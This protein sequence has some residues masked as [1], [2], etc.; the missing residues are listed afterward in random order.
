MLH[1][2]VLETRFL[3]SLL[4]NIVITDTIGD[5]NDQIMNFGNIGVGH[6]SNPYSLTIQNNNPV[7]IFITSLSTDDPAFTVPAFTTTKIQPN[8]QITVNDIRFAPTVKGLQETGL[9]LHVTAEGLPDEADSKVHLIGTGLPSDLTVTNIAISGLTS[10]YLH[11]TSDPL[12]AKATI[13]NIGDGD[14]FPTDPIVGFYLSQDL[15]LDGTDILLGSKA[16]LTALVAGSSL[17]TQNISLSNIP[18]DTNGSYYILAAA[19]PDSKVDEQNET[20]NVL[21][22][23]P[24]VFSLHGIFLTDSDT[25][26]TDQ[27]IEYGPIIAGTV[28][29]EPQYVT[30]ENLSDNTIT[31]SPYLTGPNADSFSLQ[32]V[33]NYQMPL[34]WLPVLQEFSDTQRASV[35]QMDYIPFNGTTGT[36]NTTLEYDADSNWFYFDAEKDNLISIETYLI[37]GSYGGG[38][39]P[40]SPWDSEIRIYSAY[41]DQIA[42]N[43]DINTMA[44]NFAC[45]VTM[46]TPYTGRYYVQLY[47]FMGFSH[48][49]CNISVTDTDKTIQ[50]IPVTSAGKT[51]TGQLATQYFRNDYQWYQLDGSYGSELEF[52]VNSSSTSMN[53]QIFNSLG[54]LLLENPIVSGDSYSL[55]LFSDNSYYVR[56][57]SDWR[58]YEGNASYSLAITETGTISELQPGESIQIPV[59]FTPQDTGILESY[60]TFDIT[61]DAFPIVTSENVTLRGEG[62]PLPPSDLIVSQVTLPNNPDPAILI[63]GSSLTISTQVKNIHSNNIFS[64]PVVGLYWSSDTA[65]DPSDTL[66]ENITLNGP[67]L[68]GQSITY[69]SDVILPDNTEGTFYIL[70][71]VDP[72]NAVPEINESNNV[73]ASHPISLL[74]KGSLIIIDSTDPDDDNQILFTDTPVESTVGP[75]YIYITNT[76]DQTIHLSDIQLTGDSFY[77][78]TPDEPQLP[79]GYTAAEAIQLEIGVPFTQGYWSDNEGDNF[80]TQWFYFDAP[81]NSRIDISTTDY[82]VRVY[83]MRVY[84]AY[85]NLVSEETDMYYSWQTEYMDSFVTTAAGRYY[86]EAEVYDS[87][88]DNSQHPYEML[89]SATQLTGIKA[90]PQ[91]TLPALNNSFLFVDT[92]LTTEDPHLQWKHNADWIQFTI[93]AGTNIFGTQIQIDLKA[94]NYLDFVVYNAQ[95]IPILTE[96]Y[97]NTDS[98]ETYDLVLYETGT[99]TIAVQT[100]SENEIQYQGQSSATDEIDFDLSVTTVG[101]ILDIAPGSTAVIPVYFQPQ[102]PGLNEGSLTIQTNSQASQTVVL[103]GTG[104]S[105]DLLVN[106]LEFPDSVFTGHFQSGQPLSISS[107]IYNLGPGNINGDMTVVFY[108]S[109]D[110]TF[111]PQTDTLIGSLTDLAPARDGSLLIS[112]S[113]SIPDFIARTGLPVE[114]QRYIIAVVNP[115]NTLVETD[116]TNNTFVSDLLTFSP[117][118]TIATDTVDDLYDLKLNM[119]TW[120]SGG[121]SPQ[122]EYVKLYNWS[123]ENI[124]L[125]NWSLASGENFQ[126]LNS[127][128]SGQTITIK[129]GKEV[130]IPIQFAP[131]SFEVNGTVT[132]TDSLVFK[133][134]ENVTYTASLRGT[135]I[136][137]DLILYENSGTVNDDSL[138]LG[139]ISVGQTSSPVTFTLYNNGNQTLNINNFTWLTGNQ[140]FAL[141]TPATPISLAPGASQNFTV[142]FT[143]GITGAVSDTL[144]IQSN[145]GT[146]DY[147]LHVNAAGIASQL[148]LT[149]S[150][151][152]PDD[153]KMHFGSLPVNQPSQIATV[154]IQNNGTDILE[155]LNWSLS[156]GYFSVTPADAQIPTTHILIN[157]GQ[158]IILNVQFLAQGNGYLHDSLVINSNNG[159]YSVDLT[160]YAGT[161][162]V[163]VTELNSQ[164]LQNSQLALGTTI[165]GTSLSGGVFLA[166]DSNV[167]L[168]ISSLAIQ[169]T[170]FQFASSGTQTVAVNQTLLPGEKIR[171]DVVFAS[172]LQLGSGNFNGTMIINSN[173]SQSQVTLLAAAVTP[174]ID[175]H[176]PADP[177]SSVHSLTFQNINV[178][179][180]ATTQIVITNDPN[181]NY[182]ADLVIYS[183]SVGSQFSTSLSGGE[184]IIPV[185]QSYTFSVTYNPDTYGSVHSAL[186]LQ[187]NDPDE[188]A[189]TIDLYGSSDGKALLVT[190]EASLPF[191]DEDGD[192]VEVSLS[193][194]TALVYLNNGKAGGA[195][196]RDIILEGTNSSSTL[197]INVK[198]TGSSV[199]H[200][201]SNSDLGSIIAPMVSLS[202]GVT[203]A[204]FFE[205]D[206]NGSLNKLL[207]DNIMDNV[208]IRTAAASSKAMNIKVNTIYNNVSFDLAGTVKSFQAAS[209]SSGALM[210]S[211]INKVKISAGSLGADVIADSQ[212]SASIKNIAV[213]GTISGSIRAQ[214]IKSIS[215]LNLDQA[216]ISAQ[217]TIGKVKIKNNVSDSFVLAGYDIGTDL[218][219]IQD[220]TLQTGSIGSF[221]FGGSFSNT[222]VAA[223]AMTENIYTGLYSLLPSNAKYSA[224]S[225]M[226]KVTGNTI[227]TGSGENFGF[228]SAGDIKTSFGSTGNFDVIRNI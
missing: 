32:Y 30:V 114:A 202:Q 117:Y 168:Y 12:Y 88:G 197:K 35:D 41:G 155:I 203:D 157:P 104:I 150:L 145:N 50:N 14:A 140:G 83:E 57:E 10:N 108:L 227:L 132:L 185:G 216:L 18:A 161:P 89:V 45:Q 212:D 94:D 215:A 208:D 66:L 191:F 73:L 69:N 172:S 134:S 177:S 64:D 200:I 96:Q 192:L 42:W 40:E 225:G 207:M 74:P 205:I 107:T 121:A 120:V 71:V 204:G 53:I 62:L 163:L 170:G 15:N 46:A 199:A 33:A 128:S 58:L 56:I 29:E 193:Q 188:S 141:Q 72:A 106:N 65:F 206:I 187:T 76:S 9:Y 174:E 201:F 80:G 180:T 1:L 27:L 222:Y 11:L 2:E 213:K 162:S 21:A 123:S 119:G 154:S 101:S 55:T 52:K 135:I 211:S 223:G 159:V 16:S 196:I 51:V 105:G 217:N 8:S 221:S 102:K 179:Q 100:W 220:D 165:V 63:S 20:N 34:V 113:L 136:G 13:T 19:D 137:T 181:T 219:S 146:G 156:T 209:Y 103:Q 97:E 126:L 166:N 149:D 84:N 37:S 171:A 218:A 116:T 54:E 147:A 93:P 24:I 25:P 31:I 5:P 39:T 176:T 22:S 36:I 86:I 87:S 164:V 109:E 175:V 158:S 75:E 112:G 4:D 189:Y 198:G 28:S 129:P 99:Y 61:S 139:N 82:N 210:A 67:V 68:A 111:Q 153:Y 81:A 143:A 226:M 173:A 131:Q 6:S 92:L 148:T 95:G 169:G 142:T 110:T 43:D 70:A 144:F 228:Y 133:T 138:E 79:V 190:P 59:W 78:Q 26:A 186:T 98:R 125:V 47:S 195:D 115:D 3:L 44:T 91:F 152:I 17:T 183:W 178:G 182:S 122:I 90:L 224:G 130:I 85:G 7:P 127:Q 160:G 49:N 167:E 118:H 194:G 151:G 184:L 214:S 124:N 60:L 38:P 48:G 77:F 23:V